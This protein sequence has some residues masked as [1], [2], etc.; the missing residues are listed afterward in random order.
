LAAQQREGLANRLQRAETALKALTPAAG[1]GKRVIREAEALQT[2]ITEIL[3]R[4]QVGDLLA[5]QW[6][7]LE[8]RNVRYIGR[9][10]GG[11]QREQREEVDRRCRITAVEHDTAAIAAVEQGFGWQLQIT[12]APT[13]RLDLAQATAAYREGWH[14]EHSF[15]KVKDHPI[16]LSPLFVWQEG[17]VVG[18]TRLLTLALR[19]LTLIETQVARGLLEADTSLTRLYEGQPKRAT[20][21]PTAARL[22]KAVSRAEITLTEAHMA[23]HTEWYLTPL[24]PWLPQVM[25]YLKLPPDLYE[26]LAEN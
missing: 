17:Q 8:E 6:E 26:G 23:E 11:P 25:R 1:R 12:N 5:V 3:D 4:Y 9:G 7:V 20:Q 21:Q 22:L 15:H 18:M 16:G 2:Q 24:P 13:E 14:I 10:R 19:L